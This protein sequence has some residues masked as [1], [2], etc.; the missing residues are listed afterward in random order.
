M[1]HFCCKISIYFLTKFDKIITMK[2]LKIKKKKNKFCSHFA[3]K[4]QSIP[5]LKNLSRNSYYYWNKSALH[6]LCMSCF[7]AD[8]SMKLIS[9]KVISI[10]ITFNKILT[11]TEHVK[12]YS[13]FII[14]F[15]FKNL[16]KLNVIFYEKIFC[17]KLHVI[18]FFYIKHNLNIKSRHAF[19]R[20]NFS[21]FHIQRKTLSLTR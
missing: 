15:Y 4:W 1:L 19:S 16:V 17:Q 20:I 21:Y 18:H 8:R 3:N 14:F 11:N 12:N 2:I 5:L 7:N 13:S 10:I 9:I 6:K